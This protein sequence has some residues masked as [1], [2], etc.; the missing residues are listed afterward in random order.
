MMFSVKA[1][2]LSLR[3]T[4]YLLVTPAGTK[5][6]ALLLKR[7]CAH[8]QKHDRNHIPDLQGRA[9]PLFHRQCLTP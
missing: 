2:I 8:A 7:P 1:F 3:S 9:V 5:G 4:V 6:A